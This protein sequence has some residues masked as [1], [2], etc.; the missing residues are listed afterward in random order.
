MSSFDFNLRKNIFFILHSFSLQDTFAESRSRTSAY[1]ENVVYW[2]RNLRY[3]SFWTIYISCVDKL[4]VLGK[5]HGVILT[6][7]KCESVCLLDVS[8]KAALR[9]DRTYIT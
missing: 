1:E 3:G 6:E 2:D 4:I 5:R 7:R 9:T 8:K